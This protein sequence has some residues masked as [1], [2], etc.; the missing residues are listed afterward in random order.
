[1]HQFLSWSSYLFET[2]SWFSFVSLSSFFFLC[3]TVA[4]INNNGYEM[5]LKTWSCSRCYSSQFAIDFWW[6]WTQNQ[7]A[8]WC[9]CI[10]NILIWPKNMNFTKYEKYL[11]SY[12]I[13]YS[14]NL[15]FSQYNS[16][17]G[18]I[19]NGKFRSTIFTSNTTDSSW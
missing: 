2:N 3:K 4:T 11:F 17:S 7:I 13:F 12:P 19:F 1:M 5:F 14:M 16:A 15:L 8:N 18:C 9:S 10:S 6:W